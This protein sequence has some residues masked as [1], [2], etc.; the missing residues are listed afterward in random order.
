[1][2][3]LFE[4]GEIVSTPAAL[5]AMQAKGILPG[6]LLARH[7]SGDWGQL[8]EE[9]KKENA[10]SIN[11]HLRIFSAYIINGVKLW[12]ITEADRSSTCI[13]LPENY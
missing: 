5:E 13:L 9:D 10:F 7:E 2:K 11:K 4:L 8:E 6:V 12:I 1:M 3:K